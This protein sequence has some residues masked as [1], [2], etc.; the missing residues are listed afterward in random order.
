MK[1]ILVVLSILLFFAGH[2]SADVFNPGRP[3]TPYTDGYLDLQDVFNAMAVGT[4][5]NAIN[6]QSSAAVWKPQGSGGSVSTFIFTDIYG[7]DDVIGLYSHAN[8]SKKLSVFNGNDVAGTQHI[9]QFFADGSVQ[10]DFNPAT[11]ITGFGSTFGY[12]FLNDGDIVPIAYTEDS[13]NGGEALALAYAGDGT[14]TIKIGDL[15]AGAFALNEW[16]IAFDG[17]SHGRD[18]N[19]YLKDFN[20]AVFLVES[21][22]P[23]PEPATLL[24]L[25]SGLIGL[26]GYAR[27]RF[28]K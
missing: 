9:V 8:P 15:A 3:I 17:Y 12:Y 25:G 5:I 23:V 20:D 6:G 28:K 18:N 1:K 2:A 26:A 24:L 14:K 10:I 27:R 16:I 7:A 21:V 4:P 19:G 22:E 13:L 11:K